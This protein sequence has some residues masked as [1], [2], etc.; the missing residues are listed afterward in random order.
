MPRGREGG[1][2][3]KALD[4]DQVDVLG[5]HWSAGGAALGLAPREFGQIP[6]DLERGVPAGRVVRAGGSLGLLIVIEAV[7]RKYRGL[8]LCRMVLEPDDH[9]ARPV[10]GAGRR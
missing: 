9:L 10:L 1:V 2:G 7:P 3:P 5:G 6:R 8:R 4:D